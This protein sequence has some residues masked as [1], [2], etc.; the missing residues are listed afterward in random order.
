VNTNILLLM[1]PFLNQEGYQCTGVVVERQKRVTTRDNLYPIDS[2]WSHR[3]LST[4]TR[5]LD[6]HRSCPSRLTNHVRLRRS[7]Q[8]KPLRDGLP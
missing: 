8:V 3:E 5:S 1:F 4:P 2:S 6:T 7:I